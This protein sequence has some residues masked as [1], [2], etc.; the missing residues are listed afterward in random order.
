LVECYNFSCALIEKTC[1]A[2]GSFSLSLKKIDSFSYNIFYDFPSPPPPNKHLYNNNKYNK[3]KAN[4][5]VTKQ[6]NKKEP[7]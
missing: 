7:K 2:A 1:V 4:W 6:P 5:N 3:I